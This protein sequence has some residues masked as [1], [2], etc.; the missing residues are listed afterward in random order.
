MAAVLSSKAFTDSIG[1]EKSTSLLKHHSAVMLL[2]QL[3]KVGY[4]AYLQFKGTPPGD[5]VE[6]VIKGG[7]SVPH[8]FSS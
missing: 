7:L 6:A 4:F 3:D 8:P 5:F 1:N 2:E